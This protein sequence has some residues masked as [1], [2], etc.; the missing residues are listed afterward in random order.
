MKGYTGIVIIGEQNPV[1]KDCFWQ[2]EVVDDQGDVLVI[3]LE[4]GRRGEVKRA[5]F[6]P[7]Y[8]YKGEQE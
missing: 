6:T 3:E 7:R 8:F 5:E 2:A 1:S 4:D